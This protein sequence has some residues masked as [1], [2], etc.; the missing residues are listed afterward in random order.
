MSGVP[1]ETRWA[2]KKLWNNEFYYNAA[3]FWYFYR[4]KLMYGLHVE[5]QHNYMGCVEKFIYG[6]VHSR[7]SCESKRKK[8]VTFREL[9]CRVSYIKFEWNIKKGLRDRGPSMDDVLCGKLALLRINIHDKGTSRHCLIREILYTIFK[10]I[11][12]IFVLDA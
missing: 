5:L 12:E 10:E 8:I 2:F 6:H 3:S 1:L 7:F 11:I 9:L 4:G